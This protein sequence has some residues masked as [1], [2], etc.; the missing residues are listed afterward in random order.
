[1]W[2]CARYTFWLF[3]LRC[4]LKRWGCKEWNP[5]RH[6]LQ[7]LIGN[8]FSSVAYLSWYI[9]L[10]IVATKS[11][12]CCA[13]PVSLD[14]VFLVSWYLFVSEDEP[15]YNLIFDYIF[16]ALIRC[17]KYVKWPTNALWFYGYNFLHSSL[18]HVLATHVAIFR[19]VR[20]RKQ[21]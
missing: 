20:T 4:C 9:L 3:C 16:H 8:I 6:E 18:Q 13:H 12:T 10:S 15:H 7:T 21:V 5:K 14:V 17:I 11:F 19:V 2:P 1:V